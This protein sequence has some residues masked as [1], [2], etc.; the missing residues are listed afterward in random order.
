M[1]KKVNY[2]AFIRQYE[3]IIVSAIILLLVIIFS[4]VFL[5]PNLNRVQL[6]FRQQKE[7]TK[8][9]ANLKQKDSFLSS[10]DY[11]YYKDVFAKMNYILPENKD[12]VSLISTFEKLERA[13]GVSIVKTEFQLGVV[14]T[15]SARLIKAP[16]AGGYLL[17]IGIEL[18]G[19]KDAVEKFFDVLYK[20]D[21]RLMAVEDIQWTGK[22]DG[23]FQVSLKGQSYFYPLPQALGSV[24]TPL[25]KIGGEQEKIL[26]EIAKMEIS[27]TGEAETGKVTLGKK[28]L[29]Q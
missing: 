22:E 17:P 20:F 29:F 16:V 6:I 10:L 27:S 9:I 3:I 4:Y 19:N 24:D 26:A 2:L 12:Y 5:L 23:T 8:K 11:A 7:L 25:P 21:G 15:P 18:S 14:S 28:N 13:S 1:K